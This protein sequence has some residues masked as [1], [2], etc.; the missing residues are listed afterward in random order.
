[1]TEGRKKP[2]IGARAM[3]LPKNDYS[4]WLSWRVNNS[5]DNKA[6]SA[7]LSWTWEWGLAWQLRFASTIYILIMNDTL[8]YIL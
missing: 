2:L 7:Q 4:G 3:A 6:I 8:P 5:T 1:M